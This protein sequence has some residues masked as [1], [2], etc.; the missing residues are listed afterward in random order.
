MA[1]F[2]QGCP[3][4]LNSILFEQIACHWKLE[5]GKCI[6]IFIYAGF[7]GIWVGALAETQPRGQRLKR[8]SANKGLLRGFPGESDRKEAVPKET[9]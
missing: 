1:P 3:K 2:A 4:C 6:S 8:I 7:V 5:N 9:A